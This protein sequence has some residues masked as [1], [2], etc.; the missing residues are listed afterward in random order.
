MSEIE[1]GKPGSRAKWDGS[2]E[3]LPVGVDVLILATDDDDPSL[4]ARRACWIR[5]WPDNRDFPRYRSC[6]LSEL[7]PI[8]AT[9]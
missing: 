8:R 2:A 3:V 9:P 1:F 5:Y 6:D 4:P 7:S